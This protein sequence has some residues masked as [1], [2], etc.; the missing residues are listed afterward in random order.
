MDV[1]KSVF[2]EST[3]DRSLPQKISQFIAI[4][5]S[6]STIFA[7]NLLIFSSLFIEIISLKIV[8]GL[9]RHES[10][11]V[12]FVVKTNGTVDLTASSPSWSAFVV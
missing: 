5:V 2:D 12:E 10:N 9:V 7:L 4:Q 8:L 6:K 3:E 1:L 11:K